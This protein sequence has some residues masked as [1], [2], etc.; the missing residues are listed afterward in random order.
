MQGRRPRALDLDDPELAESFHKGEQVGRLHYRWTRG[1]LTIS[2]DLTAG[3]PGPLLLRVTYEPGT[4]R[5]WIA[6]EHRPQRP[7]LKIVG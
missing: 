5:G 7:V 3:L 1:V 4:V 6:P 2:A